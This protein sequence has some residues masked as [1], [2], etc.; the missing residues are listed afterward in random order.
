MNTGEIIQD[1]HATHHLL[2]EGTSFFP[3]NLFR[4]A[5]NTRGKIKPQDTESTRLQK[6]SLMNNTYFGATHHDI[7]LDMR[8]NYTTS[9]IFQEISLSELETLHQLCELERTQILQSLALGV[10]NI[11]DIYYQEL[12]QTSLTMRET[13]YGFILAPKKYHLLMF[14][15]INDVT[16]E[17]QN[18]FKIKNILL[19]HFQEENIFGI[20]QSH[21]DQKIATMLYN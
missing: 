9:I 1:P 4:Y 13:I 5:G 8:L 19:I 14:L 15:K 6:L 2:N 20:Q 21:V 18:S 16:K 17:F 10:L 3:V 7:Y 12:D 11:Q